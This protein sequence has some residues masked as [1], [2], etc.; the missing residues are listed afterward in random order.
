MSDAI[1]RIGDE[2]Q[3]ELGNP[4]SD[5]LQSQEFDVIWRTIK[6]WDVNVPEFYS[7]HCGANGAHVVMILE[8][9]E[10]AGLLRPLRREGESE[11]AFNSRKARAEADAAEERKRNDAEALSAKEKTSRVWG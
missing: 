8:A 9:L 7:G 3:R 6:S 10:D 1:Q 4:S 5:Q 11:E 2:P